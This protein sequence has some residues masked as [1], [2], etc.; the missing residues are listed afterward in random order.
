MNNAGLYKCVAAHGGEM[1]WLFVFG[2][3]FG[4]LFLIFKETDKFECLKFF[5]ILMT[6]SGAERRAMLLLDLKIL[7]VPVVSCEDV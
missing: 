6:F 7:S 5:L 1:T 4:N 3:I 2:N